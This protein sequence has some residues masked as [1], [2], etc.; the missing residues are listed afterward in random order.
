MVLQECGRRPTN[1]VIK[2][3]V[4]LR[5]IANNSSFFTNLSIL[6]RVAEAVFT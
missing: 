1:L 5:S 6:S 3:K 4:L 2:V